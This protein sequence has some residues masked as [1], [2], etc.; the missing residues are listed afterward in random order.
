VTIVGGTFNGQ[1]IPPY[2]GT[3]TT[4]AAATAVTQAVAAFG[5][6]AVP[7]T[8]ERLGTTFSCGFRKVVVDTTNTSIYF[9]GAGHTGTSKQI[10]TTISF[11]F[12]YDRCGHLESIIVR[13]DNA[14]IAAF[15]ATCPP[16]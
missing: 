13:G 5:S 4:T 9:C 7:V 16:V 12:F 15:Y 11:E 3:Y 14:E 1:P 10:T 8:A 6:F 2:A